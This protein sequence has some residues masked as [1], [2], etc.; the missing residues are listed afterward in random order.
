M[1]NIVFVNEHSGSF[2]KNVVNNVIQ[3][4]KIKF[5][6]VEKYVG[7]YNPETINKEINENSDNLF[8]IITQ[9]ANHAKELSSL[10]NLEN[11]RIIFI[12]GGDGMTHEVVNGIHTNDTYSNKLDKLVLSI[13]PLGSGNHLSKALNI[14][15]IDDWNNSLHGMKIM[16]V[17]PSVVHTKENKQ[18]L[19]I[20]TIIGGI[21]QLI[22][23]TSSHISKY[24][25]RFVGWLKYD[26]STLYNMFLKFD[27]N[28]TLHLGGDDEINNENNKNSVHDIIAIFI[29]TTQS[30]GS[31]LVISKNIKLDQQNI[32]LS[33]FSQHGKFRIL[34]EFIKEKF[35]YES[36]YMTR[37]IDKYSV[38]YLEGSKLSNVTVD[39]QNEKIPIDSIVMIKKSREFFNFIYLL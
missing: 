38:I 22:N 9:Y 5:D 7:D 19:S 10:I 4:I 21:P 23:D 18:V 24:I 26:L 33:Y 36:K 11:I 13:V 15:S 34:Y 25:P 3:S 28:I 29:Q 16:T 37:I 17:F 14:N 8:I 32:S 35:G 39:G 6:S 20:N 31:D 12:V 2:D 27:N 30:C 1:N